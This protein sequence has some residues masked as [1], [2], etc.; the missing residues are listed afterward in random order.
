MC[1]GGRWTDGPEH[2][3]EILDI[4]ASAVIEPLPLASRSSVEHLPGASWKRTWI[5]SPGRYVEH[6]SKVVSIILKDASEIMS[7]K[8]PC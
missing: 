1:A 5:R 6:Q 8:R 2:S 4:T 3:I 7:G